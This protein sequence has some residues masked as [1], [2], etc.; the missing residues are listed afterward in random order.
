MVERV[1]RAMALA[2]DEDF[3]EDAGRY[4]RRARAAIEA[5]RQ[6]TQAMRHACWDTME[7]NAAVGNCRPGAIRGSAF[8]DVILERMID[9]ALD[10]C[11]GADQAEDGR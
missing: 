2:D 11:T 7:K 5:I 10:S 6:P 4:L 1:A 8:P 9:A 3:V